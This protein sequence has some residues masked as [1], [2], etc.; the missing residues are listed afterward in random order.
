M[1]ETLNLQRVIFVHKSIFFNRIAQIFDGV[2][3]FVHTHMR[4]RAGF[5]GFE[6]ELLLLSLIEF[7]ADGWEFLQ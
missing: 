4:A 2:M 5:N 1:R 3:S 7:A 6:L